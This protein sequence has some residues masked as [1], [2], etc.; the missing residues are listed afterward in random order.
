MVTIVG[1]QLTFGDRLET[2]I[3]YDNDPENHSI[4]LPV[5]RQSR[6]VVVFAKVKLDGI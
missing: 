2:G 5:A 1:W 3:V 4:D 6:V